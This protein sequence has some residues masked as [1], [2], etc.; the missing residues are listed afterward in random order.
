MYNEKKEL[1][2]HMRQMTPNFNVI[3]G[4]TIKIM[5]VLTDVR[6]LFIIP[7]IIKW[8]KENNCS[9]GIEYSRNPLAVDYTEAWNVLA[10][11]E[12]NKSFFLLG[13]LT[14]EYAKYINK[15]ITIEGETEN[16]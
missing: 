16:E 14:M 9:V 6:D 8:G 12:E 13:Y 15:E 2:D 11:L 3:D 5:N 10:S 1:L 7:T 4:K